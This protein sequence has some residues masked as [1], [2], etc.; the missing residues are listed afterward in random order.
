MQVPWPVQ[1]RE[2]PGHFIMGGEH[3]P[4][5]QY[6]KLQSSS[7]LQNWSFR[8]GKQLP[9]QSKSLS[10]PSMTPFRQCAGGTEHFS[11]FRSSL[12]VYPSRHLPHVC[13][14]SPVEHSALLRAWQL[15]ASEQ[16]SEFRIDD[17]EESTWNTPL[18]S[19][20]ARALS[21]N[22]CVKLASSAVVSLGVVTNASTEA[23]EDE[24]YM[25]NTLV[26]TSTTD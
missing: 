2:S 4:S 17:E 13:G 23:S 25:S 7:V 19:P 20:L 10:S 11:N 5:S 18:V 12:L 15:G 21:D 3:T 22:A 14:V 26:N 1:G 16:L 24:P 6:F 9:P 8:Q